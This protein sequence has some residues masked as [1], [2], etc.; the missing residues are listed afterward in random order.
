MP[1]FRAIQEGLADNQVLWGDEWDRA[2]VERNQ[3]HCSLHLFVQRI[4]GKKEME[5][6][7]V[8]VELD[9]RFGLQGS[10]VHFNR[11]PE[12]SE[13]VP[14]LRPPLHRDKDVDVDVLRLP[15]L[16]VVAQRKRAAEGV[17]DPGLLQAAVDRLD[18]G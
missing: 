8:P 6:V 14:H 13:G 15:R 3:S 12:R 1:V 7:L 10:F 2:V 16:G 9:L 5:W 17:R 4:A 11:N 18:L